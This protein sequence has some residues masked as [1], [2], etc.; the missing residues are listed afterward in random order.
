MGPPPT[1]I[2]SGLPAAAA[3]GAATSDRA[4]QTAIGEATAA[5]RPA[6]PAAFGIAFHLHGSQQRGREIG[7]S[8]ARFF[9]FRVTARSLVR[10]RA[11]GSSGPRRRAKTLT[12]GP[13]GES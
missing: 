7:G 13:V 4:T 12:G 3:D 8:Q 2:V 6:F 11:T 5:I 10:L 1:G 9:G